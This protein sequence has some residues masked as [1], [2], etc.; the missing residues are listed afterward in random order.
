MYYKVQLRTDINYRIQLVIYTTA[1]FEDRIFMGFRTAPT[2]FAGAETQMYIVSTDVNSYPENWIVEAE[3]FREKDLREP[4]LMVQN[5]ILYFYF[6]ELGT[7]PIS[8]DPG[9][10]LRMSR[11]SF[12]NWSSPQEWGHKGECTWQF[13]THNKSAY[14]ISFS[15]TEGVTS[16]GQVNLFLNRSS[17]GVMW[18]PVDVE[19]PILYEN[20]G[21]SE[22]R[23]SYFPMSLKLE[24]SALRSICNNFILG[25]LGI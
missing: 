20:G 24:T 8:F 14:A 6:I 19:K 11:I 1:M 5:A 17:D 25:W 21:I 2:H 23:L 9:T 4:Y 12:G 13:N 7:N 18:K 16:L 15:G 22:V 3:I 10:L